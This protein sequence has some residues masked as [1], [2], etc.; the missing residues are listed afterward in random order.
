MSDPSSPDSHPDGSLDP[1][2][3]AAGL[4][5]YVT[6]SPTSFHAAAA[7]RDR[8]VAAGFTALEDVGAWPAGPGSYVVVRD[9]AVIAWRVPQGAGPDTPFRVLG[10]HTD[11]PGF[12]L[13]PNPVVRAH[14]W[15]QLNVE[16]YGG[17]VLPSWFDRDLAL[18]GRVVLA[19]GTTRL[20]RTGPLARIPH[21]AIHLDRGVNEGFAPD[22]QRHLLPVVGV[23]GGPDPDDARHWLRAE[24]GDAVAAD[25][26]LADTQAPARLGADGSL[27]ASARMDNLTSVHAGLHGLLAAPQDTP[28]MPVLAAFDHEEVGSGT[29]T[30]AAGPFLEEV[31]ARTQEGFGATR[32]QAA[33]AL[34]ASWLLSSDAGHLVHP[35]HPDR[36]DPTNRPRPGGGPLLKVN[37]NQRYMTDARGEAL[38]AA[39]CARAGVPHQPYVN[40]NTV[41]GGSTIGPLAA[42]RLG[43]PTVDVGVGL[44]SMHSARELVHVEDLA[45]LHGAVAAFLAG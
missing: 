18:A 12:R 5:H 8:L 40:P 25:L 32:S 37:A 23:A 28:H 33:S 44:L 20:V 45:A 11:S 36:H 14:G 38:F 17:P 13:K 16:V 22:R 1:D 2:G 29:P 3:V 43:I 30:G 7:A 9:G 27:L 41:P 35:G 39:A 21:L 34:R 42:T 10:A 4:A 31:I 6:Q 15:E 26:F 24:L 19:D